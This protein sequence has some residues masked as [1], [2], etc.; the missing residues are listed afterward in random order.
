[1]NEFLNGA[2]SRTPMVHLYPMFK[3]LFLQKKEKQL[4]AFN[5]CFPG[6]ISSWSAV[7]DDKYSTVIQDAKP[8]T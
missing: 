5:K 3:M 1:M 8:S 2:S 6:E 4:L 7:N